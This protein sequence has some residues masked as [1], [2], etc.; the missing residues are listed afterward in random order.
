M[1]SN[2]FYLENGS[3][4]NHRQQQHV[5]PAA[6][7]NNSPFAPIGYSRQRSTSLLPTIGSHRHQQQHH[8]HN[9]MNNHSSHEIKSPLGSS[10]SSAYP[11]YMPS[12]TRSGIAAN[13]AAHDYYMMNNTRLYPLE[14]S[15]FLSITHKNANHI[16]FFVVK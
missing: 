5:P 6:D 2:N 4:N 10:S 12:T 13:V 11:L 9:N 7:P 16:K 8:H 14:S 3:N 15:K 1:N